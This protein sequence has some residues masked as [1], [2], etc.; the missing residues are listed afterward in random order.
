MARKQKTIEDPEALLQNIAK[1]LN[2]LKIPYIITGGFAV[3]VWGRPRFTA[4]IVV[5]IFEK[6]I[7]SL[8]KGL[9]SLGQES[10]LDE[11]AIKRAL[12]EKGEF[13]FIHLPTGLKVDF[14]IK[15]TDLDKLKIKQ[16]IVKK[17]NNQPIKFISPENLILSKL[18]WYK[19]TKS[20]REIEDIK[21]IL[22]FT[23]IDLNYLKKQ[24]IKHNI[25]E[26]WLK[27]IDINFC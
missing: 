2:R 14:W 23:K 7:T 19:K 27:L 9:M 24:A 10:Y 17:I 4:D 22:K 26:N 21:S 1:I 15:K 5:E 18:L 11:T 8:S 25:N 3:A 12:I 20:D 6:N 13:N 16:G